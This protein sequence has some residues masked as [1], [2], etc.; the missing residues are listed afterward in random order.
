MASSKKNGGLK[1]EICNE[2]ITGEDPGVV[3]CLNPQPEHRFTVH[4]SC[5]EK[6]A[7]REAALVIKGERLGAVCPPLEGGGAKPNMVSNTTLKVL[8][9]SHMLESLTTSGKKRVASSGNGKISEKLL[10]KALEVGTLDVRLAQ[11]PDST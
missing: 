3:S 6:L 5:V 7:S 4:H 10:R 8:G 11:D 1:C 9:L 2:A